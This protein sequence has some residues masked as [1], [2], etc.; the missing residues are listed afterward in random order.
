MNTRSTPLKKAH[1]DGADFAALDRKPALALTLFIKTLTGMTYTLTCSVDDTIEAVQALIQERAGI[2]ADHQRFIWAGRQLE[3]GRTLRDYSVPDESTFQLVLRLHDTSALF[4]KPSERV[5]QRPPLDGRQKV[6]AASENLR[7]VEITDGA[8]LM[9]TR[10]VERGVPCVLRRAGLRLDVVRAIADPAAWT[11]DGR[12][13]VEVPVSLLHSGART[14]PPFDAT[15]MSLGR[16]VHDLMPARPPARFYLQQLPFEQYPLLR[17][18]LGSP[19]VPFDLQP[20]FHAVS[21]FAAPAGV[22]T[23]LQSDR[24]DNI[25]HPVLG[26]EAGRPVAS[27]RSR[28][29]ARTQRSAAGRGVECRGRLEG[30]DGARR[31]AARGPDRVAPRVTD[32]RSGPGSATRVGRGLARISRRAP[33]PAVSRAGGR[34]RPVYSAMVVAYDL[35]AGGRYGHQLVVLLGRPHP[36]HTVRTIKASSASAECRLFRVKLA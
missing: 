36:P 1:L 15:R 16:Y 27:R 6:A 35:L 25:F 18:W 29:A 19:Q 2:P 33:A 13:D 3:E 5:G 12:G 26:A 17:A 23:S 30:C 4:L 20:D 7:R 21:I 14:G 22:T 8:S 31:S 32:L 28:G 24:R 11:Q 10:L 9:Y 34:R